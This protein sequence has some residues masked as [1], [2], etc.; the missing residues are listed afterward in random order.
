[1]CLLPREKDEHGLQVFITLI[2]G[3]W[4]KE[5]AKERQTKGAR[6][7]GGSHRN[8]KIPLASDGGS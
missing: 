8:V 6:Y 1:M 3:V 2:Q 7:L 5:E 4:M